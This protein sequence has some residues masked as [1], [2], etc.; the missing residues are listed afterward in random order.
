MKKWIQNTAGLILSV[1]LTLGLGVKVRAAGEEE[2]ALPA[3][4]PTEAAEPAPAA[5]EPAAGT[6]ALPESPDLALAR[7]DPRPFVPA[8]PAAR[9]ARCREILSIQSA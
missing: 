5:P 6:P 1:F 4:A 8:D 2:D 3:P 9:D 7:L